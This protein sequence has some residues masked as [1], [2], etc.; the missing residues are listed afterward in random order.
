MLAEN[1]ITEA[2]ELLE[3]ASLLPIKHFVEENTEKHNMAITISKSGKVYEVKALKSGYGSFE[4]TIADI[5][6]QEKNRV[7]QARD[8]QQ[9]HARD[10]HSAYFYQRLS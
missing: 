2:G 5:T 6:E 7:F 9:Y 8:D 1:P 10:T 4:I 3:E